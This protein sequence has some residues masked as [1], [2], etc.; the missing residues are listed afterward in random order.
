M[1]INIDRVEARLQTI[2]AETKNLQD[3]LE[4][5]QAEERDITTF[6]RVYSEYGMAEEARASTEPVENRSSRPPPPAAAVPEQRVRRRGGHAPVDGRDVLKREPGRR[7][8]EIA[9]EILRQFRP[10]EIV[11]AR[12]VAAKFGRKFVH[13]GGKIHPTHYL[14]AYLNKEAQCA[15]GILER[16][17]DIRGE[18]RIKADAEEL[19]GSLA[20]ETTL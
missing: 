10:G 14:S 16:T 19:L 9:Q 17:G 4:T 6:M 11:S 20:P 2:R 7:Q 5:L 8:T 1:K 12:V 13:P 15:N 18:Y 3:R